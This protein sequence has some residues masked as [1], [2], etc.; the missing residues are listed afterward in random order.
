MAAFPLL[1][2]IIGEALW[3]NHIS[4]NAEH[5]LVFLGFHV[6]VT[7]IS[8]FLGAVL[9]ITVSYLGKEELVTNVLKPFDHLRHS[10][11]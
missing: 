4:N 8:T 9:D 6:Y 11:R 5:G 7:L 10:K 3:T 1:G 2:A